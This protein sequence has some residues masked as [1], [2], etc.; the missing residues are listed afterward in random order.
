[1]VLVDGGQQKPR[2]GISGVYSVAAVS[3]DCEVSA[4]RP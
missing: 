4:V 2:L 1:M 3:Q